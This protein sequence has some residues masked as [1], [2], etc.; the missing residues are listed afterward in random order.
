MRNLLKALI[1]LIT[2][3]SVG[4]TQYEGYGDDKVSDESIILNVTM[5]QSR[6]KTLSSMNPADLAYQNDSISIYHMNDHRKLVAYE[7]YEDKLDGILVYVYKDIISWTTARSLFKDY[8]IISETSP[9]QGA[10]YY[11]EKNIYGEITSLTKDGIE[12]FCIGFNVIR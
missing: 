6:D 3:L 10:Y 2:I 7:F 11:R 4:C 1:L 12:Y 5:T 9:K 8:E